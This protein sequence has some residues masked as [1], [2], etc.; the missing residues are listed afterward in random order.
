MRSHRYLKRIRAAFYNKNGRQQNWLNLKDARSAIR[1]YQRATSDPAGTLELM[2]AHVEIGTRFTREFGDI[3]EVFYNSLC[4]TLH[5]VR[6]LIISEEGRPLY[7]RVK[8]RLAALAQEAYGIGWG[9]GDYVG[10]VVEELQRTLGKPAQP[11][12]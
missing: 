10:D 9:Y 2:L 5:D 1:E 12:A 8:G 7:E 4:S 6:I 3:T 11:Q